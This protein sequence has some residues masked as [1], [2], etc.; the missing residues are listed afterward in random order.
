MC[1]RDSPRG[2]GNERQATP[3]NDAFIV[4]LGMKEARGTEARWH[5]IA[6][7]E[8]E[9]EALFAVLAKS[10]GAYE[11][12]ENPPDGRVAGVGVMPRE[13]FKARTIAIAKGELKP[14]ETDPKVWRDKNSD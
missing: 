4:E 6:D 13:A 14:E 2:Y 1:I 5:T 10:K 7:L 3:F 8:A 11:R 9:D 12:G